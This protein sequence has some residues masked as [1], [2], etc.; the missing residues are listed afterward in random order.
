M[1]TSLLTERVRCMVQGFAG[2]FSN[3]QEDMGIDQALRR[4]RI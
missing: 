2:V 1:E 4:S 3:M